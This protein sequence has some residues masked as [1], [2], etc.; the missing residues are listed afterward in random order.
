MSINPDRWTLKTQEAF[1]SAVERARAANNPEVTPDHVLA[2]VLDQA[3]GIAGPV[4][5]RVGVEPAVLAERIADTL[6]RLP[7]SVGGAEPGVD[8]QLRDVLDHRRLACGPTWATSTSRS[9]IWCWPWPTGS[10]WTATSC[11]PRCATSGAATG[12]RRRTPRRPFRPSSGT[13]GTSPPWPARGRW[14]RSSAGTKRCA[15]SSRCCPA[16]PRTTP[17]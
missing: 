13:A 10:A 6:A 5:A 14:T 16:A 1:S 15:G 9:S 2:A 11:S 12:S 7:H 4:L 3:D 8:R 17:S